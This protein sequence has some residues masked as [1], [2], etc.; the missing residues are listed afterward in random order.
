MATE[1]KLRLQLDIGKILNLLANE[2]YDSPLAMAPYTEA[3]STHTIISRENKNK[4]NVAVQNR[5]YTDY[6]DNTGIAGREIFI[7]FL[8]RIYC[9]NPR[10]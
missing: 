6:K 5:V 4:T 1:E 7:Q 9:G 8:T 3:A 10:L 2:I